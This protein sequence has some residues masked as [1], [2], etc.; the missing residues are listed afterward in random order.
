M[1]L[2]KS[3]IEKQDDSRLNFSENSLTQII[4]INLDETNKFGEKRG[5]RVFDIQFTKQHDYE[6]KSS[7]PYNSQDVYD[8]PINFDHFFNGESLLQEDLVACY[9]IYV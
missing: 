2:R 7:H 6:L 3:F 9:A 1:K 8:P 4:I 5:Y